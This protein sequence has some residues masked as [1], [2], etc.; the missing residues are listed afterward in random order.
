MFNHVLHVPGADPS[1]PLFAFVLLLGQSVTGGVITS[2]GVVL[3]AMFASLA[4]LPILFLAQ[5]A[6]LVP[7]ACPRSLWP[8]AGPSGGRACRPV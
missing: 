4:V 5:I 2:A 6:F 7:S 1:V 3:A 8:S